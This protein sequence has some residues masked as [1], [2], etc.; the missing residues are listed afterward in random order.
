MR[1]EKFHKQIHNDFVPTLDE[2]MKMIDMWLNFKNSQPCPNS[3]NKTIGEVLE[4]RKRQNVDIN[5]LEIYA[6]DN[7]ITEYTLETIR[8]LL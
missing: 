5:Q 8:G 4:S 7:G 1:N 3:P 6:K 2:T